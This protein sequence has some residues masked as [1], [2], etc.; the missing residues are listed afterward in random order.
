[1]AHREGGELMVQNINMK[2][3]QEGINSFIGKRNPSWT[4]SD[5]WSNILSMLS[6]SSIMQFQG[7]GCMY[8][9][10]L[11][12]GVFWFAATVKVL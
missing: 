9:T 2:D 10:I 7:E 8:S 12:E 1:M 5:D 6:Q 11:A 4:H 3:G